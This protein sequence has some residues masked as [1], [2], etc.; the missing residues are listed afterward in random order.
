MGCHDERVSSE[1]YWIRKRE[2]PPRRTGPS[3]VNG[4]TARE[5]IDEHTEAIRNMTPEELEGLLAA[6]DA[7]SRASRAEDEAAAA[8]RRAQRYRAN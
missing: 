4:K 3:T 7:G 8:W 6:A 2:R 1:S 5:L